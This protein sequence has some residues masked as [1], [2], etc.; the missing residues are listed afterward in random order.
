MGDLWT[1][2]SEG[3]PGNHQMTSVKTSLEIE[4]T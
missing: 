1:R 2:M 4:E 3:S